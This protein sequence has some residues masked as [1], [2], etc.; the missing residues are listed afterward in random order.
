M[1]L[2]CAGG[3]GERVGRLAVGEVCFSFRYLDTRVSDE[4]MHHCVVL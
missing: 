2:G 1:R 3:R 4:V